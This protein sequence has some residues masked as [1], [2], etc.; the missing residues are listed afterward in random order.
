[1]SGQSTTHKVGR[2]RP[3]KSQEELAINRQRWR[4]DQTARDSFRNKQARERSRQQSQEMHTIQVLEE[5]ETGED[6]VN[7]EVAP[8]MSTASMFLL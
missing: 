6:E 7:T 1:M 3:R 8:R 5:E 4:A 2:G